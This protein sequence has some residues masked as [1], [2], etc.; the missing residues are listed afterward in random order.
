MRRAAIALALLFVSA[1]AHAE[2]AGESWEGPPPKAP[3][4]SA[5]EAWQMPARQQKPKEVPNGFTAK[6]WGG[7][8]YRQIYSVPIYGGDLGAAIGGQTG[9]VAAYAMFD[10]LFGHTRFGLETT[11]VHFG[12]YCEAR[13]GRFRG[14]GGFQLAYISVRRATSSATF[15]GWGP[16]L[17]LLASADLYRS[18]EGRALYFGAAFH[19]DFLV[20]PFDGTGGSVWGPTAS[21]G[22]R[23]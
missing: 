1:S 16:G 23:Y 8:A 6:L 3:P 20:L 5:P 21:V 9:H 2:N 15:E 4:S 12:G 7:P 11:Q 22:V 17:T 13:V 10:A 14:G 18:E 19:A